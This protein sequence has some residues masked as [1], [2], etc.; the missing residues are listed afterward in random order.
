[1]T[2]DLYAWKG[3]RALDSEAARAFV[4]EWLASR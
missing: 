2:F 3:P 1:M 4:A